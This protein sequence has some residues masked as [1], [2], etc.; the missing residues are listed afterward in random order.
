MKYYKYF[1]LTLGVIIVDQAVKLLVYYNMY[2]G[3]EFPIISGIDFLKIHYTTNPGMA[4]GWQIGGDYGKLILT[5][6][7][8]VAMVAIAWYLVRLAKK[9]AHSGLLWCI[10]SILGGAIGNVID[11]TFYG[12]FLQGNVIYNASTPWFHGK[13]IDMIYVDIC[14]CYFPEWIP[15]IGGGPHALW[16]IFNIADASIFVGVVVI[17]LMQK[18]FFKESK[19][20]EMKNTD[21]INS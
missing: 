10:G 17:L 15:V 7:R 13:V 9:G 5:A 3:E 2:E 11:S 18:K 6:F 4:F 20:E 21:T 14:Y 8:L 16:P 1:L 19:A 12:V